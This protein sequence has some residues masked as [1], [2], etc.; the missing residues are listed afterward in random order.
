MNL[1]G[2]LSIAMRKI[3]MM[4]HF[5]RRI[6]GL[7]ALGSLLLVGG[8]NRQWAFS[9]VDMWN[10][11][12]LKPYEAAAPGSF[13]S[14]SRPLV[15]GTVARGQLRTDEAF[16][17]GTQNGHLI[18]AL[19]TAMMQA[20]PN[21]V[22][23]REIVERGHERY[24]IYCMPC[25][26]VT[27]SGDG[28]IVKRGFSPPPSYHIA[29]LRTAPIGHFYDVITNGYGAMYSYASRV[30]PRD[31]WAIAQYIRVLQRSQNAQPGDVP[32]SLRGELQSKGRVGPSGAVP[33]TETPSLPGEMGTPHASQKASSPAP[34]G[35]LDSPGQ[36]AGSGAPSG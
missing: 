22:S 6:M 19:P 21:S 5:A 3:A 25:H 23:M 26:G 10:R 4:R 11:S 27:G 28:M 34:V 30:P 13:N 32:E 33:L 16:Y 31:R 29:R 17:N 8:C 9:P 18:T 14:S 35:P 1:N 7:G 12:R 20:G 2:L 24:N 15:R 36:P